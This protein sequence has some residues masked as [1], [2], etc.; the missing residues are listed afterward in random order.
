MIDYTLSLTVYE[1]LFNHTYSGH[2]IMLPSVFL[3][4]LCQER[5][6]PEY[7]II[8]T[9]DTFIGVILPLMFFMVFSWYCFYV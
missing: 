4:I 5:I 9:V 3:F 6:I 1:Q 7:W 2:G 8:P